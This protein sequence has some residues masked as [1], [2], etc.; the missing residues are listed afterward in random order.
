MRR[1]LGYQDFFVGIQGSIC[2]LVQNIAHARQVPPST[3]VQEVLDYGVAALSLRLADVHSARVDVAIS[4]D[5]VY[6]LLMSTRSAAIIERYKEVV[7]T[8]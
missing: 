3:V 5:L 6:G 4:Q 8:K 1:Q 7:G 2:E